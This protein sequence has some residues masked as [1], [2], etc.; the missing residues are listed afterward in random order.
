M[1]K[2][3]SML[4]KKKMIVF[5]LF[6]ASVCNLNA[7]S[8]LLLESKVV[9][10]GTE[11]PVAEATVKIADTDLVTTT[12]EK[13]FFSF[14]GEL[15]DGTYFI[16]VEKEGYESDIIPV[17][18][19][20]GVEIELVEI[21]L[22][23]T[24]KEEKRIREL[25]EKEEKDRLKKIKED[26]KK[27]KAFIKAQK[28][29]KKEEA[30]KES[31][32]PDEIA[33][34]IGGD[35]PEKKPEENVITENQTKYSE[36]LGVDITKVTNK[37]LYDFIDEWMGTPYLMGGST[38][39]AIDCSSFSQRLFVKSFDIYLERTAQTQ[40]DS[41][42]TELFKNK[43]YLS[44]GDLIFFGKDPF[45]ISH[46]GVYLH[47]NKFVH[48]TANTREGASGVKISDLTL[49]FWTNLYVSA[50]RRKTEK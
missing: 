17:E 26:E 41:E 19:L 16:S 27:L 31:E 28:K 33:D 45:N 9:R 37:E 32:E 43:E 25:E 46:V 3:Q 5:T 15:L 10:K 4:L 30:K 12:D 14:S 6:L 40:F 18:K 35:E 34:T 23:R 48:A 8:N 2:P 36:V 1:Q 42:N 39:K 29:K 44:E 7:Q 20:T 11:K 50:G 22:V 24:K 13:G 38:K 47:N 21:E 49:P